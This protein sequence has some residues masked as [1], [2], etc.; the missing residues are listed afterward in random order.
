MRKKP[1]KMKTVRAWALVNDATGQ[2]TAPI[3]FEL[4]LVQA[5]LRIRRKIDTEE[6]RLAR[7]EIREINPRKPQM[8]VLAALKP[9]RS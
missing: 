2:C 1:A 7:V 4:S 9:R 3:S 6:Y 8:M 5:S